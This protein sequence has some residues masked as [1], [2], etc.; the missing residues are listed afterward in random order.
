MHFSHLIRICTI[1]LLIA[2]IHNDSN[3]QCGDCQYQTDLIINGNFSSGNSGFTSELNYVTGLF[4]PLC[5]ENTYTIGS[6]A[7]FY[8]SGFSGTDH[9]NPPS[10]NF[11][12]ANAPGQEGSV[13]WCE[14]LT[15]QPDVDYT[16]TFWA[17]DITNNAN[18][19]PLALLQPSFNGV[20]GIDTL[21]AAGGWASLSVQWNSGTETSLLLCIVNQQSQTGGND[22]GLDD[23]SF[24][25]CE[26]YVLSQNANAGP[27]QN[28]CSNVISQLGASP[29]SG[30]SYSW[31]NSTGL[32]S[33]SIANPNLQITNVTEFSLT[34]T[35]V[36]TTDSAGV[37]CITTDTIEVTILPMPYFN[38]GENFSICPDT[39]TIL[40][41]G[42]GW[43]NISWSTGLSTQTIE[44]SA[45]IYATTVSY[46]QCTATDSITI[47]FVDLPIIDFGPDSSFCENDALILNAG[48]VGTWSNGTISDQ[49]EVFNSGEYSF[50]YTQNNC[51]VSDTINVEMFTYP[52][53]SITSDSG[54][55]QGTTLTLE[56]TISGLWSTGHVGNS[57]TIE[58]PGYYDIVAANGPCISSAGVNTNMT[59]QPVALLPL[60]YSICEDESLEL[61]AFFESNS[62]YLWSNGDS[63]SSTTINQPGSYF[64]D[65]ANVCDTIRTEV[66]VD[67]YPCSWAIYIPSSFTPNDDDI[68]ESW[69]VQGYNVTNV[70]VYVYNRLGNLIF[71]ATDL[72]LP[73]TPGTGIGDDVYNYTVEAIN[74]HG[75]SVTRHGHLYLL[76]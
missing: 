8:H 39:T 53:I 4:C 48:I 32:N 36:L 7:F 27:D 61:N 37:G 72:G 70:R 14:N 52:S 59:L 66:T 63:T 56:A 58:Q 67:T 69:T 31:N 16:F 34:Q 71:Y 23:L 11:F 18:A 68:N 47:G 30:Y 2:G 21:V 19:H 15:V 42:I 24:T 38:L 65:V 1:A 9:T 26:N 35:Y 40:D 28:I 20:L 74:F 46:N 3:A 12:I 76:R 10:G 64:V 51:Q 57:I 22:F 25:A 73:W 45:G 5:P 75:D 50:T 55:C 60:N 41:A 29:S 13:V 6:N 43:D 49:L 54:F 17:R 62:Y 44:A 33:T